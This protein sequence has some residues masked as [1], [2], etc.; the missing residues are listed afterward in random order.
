MFGEWLSGIG[1]Y[2]RCGYEDEFVVVE[3]GD[4]VFVNECV[5]DL[6]GEYMDELVIGGVV[7]V[8]VDGFEV[9]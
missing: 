6:L 7:Q 5:I 9:V 1:I 3:L 2:W 4:Q 8:V